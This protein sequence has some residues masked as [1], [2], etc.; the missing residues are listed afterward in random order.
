[1]RQELEE[2][3][4]ANPDRFKLWYTLDRPEEGMKTMVTGVSIHARWLI[5]QNSSTAVPLYI[6][7][8]SNLVKE[9][10]QEIILQLTTLDDHVRN[11]IFISPWLWTLIPCV[12]NDF[13]PTAYQLNG[14]I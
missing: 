4:T 13:L 12:V 6:F 3:Q 5:L 11:H 1:L 14:K 9:Q 2:I 10:T 7:F 8:S